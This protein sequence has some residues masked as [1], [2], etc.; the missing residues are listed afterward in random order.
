MQLG[1][2]VSRLCASLM[3]SIE[4][5]SASSSASV[6]MRFSL[7][8]RLRRSPASASFAKS[9]GIS[10]RRLLAM[11]SLS[12]FRMRYSS[13]GIIGILRLERSRI[14]LR[15]G[16]CV[17]MTTVSVTHPGA[18]S[19]SGPSDV[20]EGNSSLIESGSSRTPSTRSIR[21]RTDPQSVPFWTS[22]F[23]SFLS[24]RE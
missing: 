5:I 13:S 24:R 14:P 15:A 7:Q 22:H 23:L 11:I 21:S 19:I 16:N 10:V 2:T 12:S 8:S 6:V 1:T 4:R 9:A 17:Q 20:G 3:D 18:R